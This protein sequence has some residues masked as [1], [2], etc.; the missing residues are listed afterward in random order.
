MFADHA[1]ER[2]AAKARVAREGKASDE[3]FTPRQRRSIV[4]QLRKDERAYEAQAAALHEVEDLSV[5][6]A[7]IFAL[8]ASDPHAA[9]YDT[10]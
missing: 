5:E 1:A 4:R 10:P 2:S 6:L 3:A 9:V 8:A 7:A